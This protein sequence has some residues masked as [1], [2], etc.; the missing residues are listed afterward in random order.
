MRIGGGIER[1]M[2]LVPLIAL[3]GLITVFIGG[4]EQAL[5]SFERLAYDTWN[6][7][8]LLVRR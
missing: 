2:L 1:W 4:P 6:R 3:A 7:V 8:V 5:D